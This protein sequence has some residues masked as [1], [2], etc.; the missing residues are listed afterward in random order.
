MGSTFDF[1][2]IEG[3]DWDKGNLE[4]I[5]KHC[6]NDKECEQVLFNKPLLLRQDE[7]H[8]KTE[9]RHKALGLTNKKRLIFL[10]F[11]VRGNRIRIVSARD[12]N[13]KERKIISKN[14]EVI[15]YKQSL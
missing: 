7:I 15:I 10:A 3:F 2:R 11:T 4:H 8:S 13:K 6:V 14:K 1:S 12:Q 5:K 9:Q